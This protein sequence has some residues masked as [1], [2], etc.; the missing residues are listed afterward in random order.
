MSKLEPNSPLKVSDLRATHKKYKENIAEWKFLMASYEGTKS[1][2]EQGYLLKNERE[3]AE[4]YKRRKKGASG[5]DYSKSIIDLFNFYLFKKPVKRILGKLSADPAWVLFSVDCNLYGDGLDDFLTEDGRYS[6]IEGHVG[7]MVD[8]ASKKYETV[9]EEIENKVY[10]YLVSYFPTA[11]LDWHYERDENNR[12][13]LSYLKLLD[14]DGKYRLWWT[15]QWEIWEE[16]KSEE[17]PEGEK[18]KIRSVTPDSKAKRVSFGVNTLKEIPWVWLINIKSKDR[19]IGMSDI[20]EV[21]RLD[22]S[23]LNNI[24]QG[25]EVISYGAFPMLRKPQRESKPDGGIS[26]A[27]D[28]NVSVQAIIEFDPDNPDAKPDWLEA[29]VKE[30]VDAILTWM[31]RKTEEIYRVVNAGGM[32][33]T[34]ISTQ[35]KSGVALKAEFQLLNSSLVRKAKNL[36]KAEK[37]LIRYWC[38]WQKKEEFL[39]DISIERERTYDVEDLATDLENILTASIIVKSK[40]FN[41]RMQKKV[42]RAMLP[43]AEDDE[44]KEIDDEIDKS[45]GP[46]PVNKKELGDLVEANLK[47]DEE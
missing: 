41:D 46:E 8:K 13:Y 14:D 11:I 16:P 34:E 20:H 32:A 10:P 40:K 36:E 25:E 44:I 39:K 19:P 38:K 43:A 45:N 35:A 17:I 6:S 9:A 12:P 27:G 4:N 30:P 18:T 5:F 23:I 26:G 28:D 42:V 37:D 3:S 22:V 2:V 21:A 1:L 7:I 24:S 47:D 29:K 15:N 33:S 31:K